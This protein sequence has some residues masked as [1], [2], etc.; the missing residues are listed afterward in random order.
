MKKYIVIIVALI[1]GTFLRLYQIGHI[2][3][4]LTWDEA[5]LGYNAFSILKTGRDEFGKFLPTV[6][7]SFGDF[8]PGLY[9]YLATPFIALVGLT[10]TAVRLPSALF[11]ILSIYGIYLLVKEMFFENKSKELI[12]SFSALVLSLSPSAIH[13]SRGAWETNVF[14]TLLIFIL[15]FLFKFVRLGKY[16]NFSITLFMLSLFTYQ[17]AKILTPILILLL[18]FIYKKDFFKNINKHLTSKINLS[19]FVLFVIATVYFFAN[20]FLGPNSNRLKTLSIFNYHPEVSAET[21]LIDNNNNLSTASFHNKA[22][23]AIHLISGRYFKHLSPKLLFY[24][25]LL[26]VDRGHLPGMGS[27]L[28]FDFIF[29]ILGLVYLSR[30]KNSSGKIFLLGILII[31]PLPGSLTLSDYSTV[32]AHFSLIPIS[33]IIGMGYALIFDNKKIKYTIFTLIFTLIGF[34]FLIDNLFVHANYTYAKEFQFGYREAINFASKYPD[35]KLIM[36]DV[37]GQPYIFYLFYNQY[38]PS[39]Y[40]ST[41]HLELNNLDVGNVSALDNV[42]FHQF[43]TSEFIN[44]PNTVYAGTIGNIPLEYD[45][46]SDSSV[47]DFKNITTPNG[48]V[49]F[50]LVKT[51]NE[52]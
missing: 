7:K 21:K 41:N 37:Y 20:T 3:N 49:I 42:E 9:I 32:R 11:G 25:G 17:A 46:S 36:T 15:F 13:F 50:R 5:A 52:K 6:F 34:V 30:L 19:I 14:S 26:P 39:K 43:S 28:P 47:E 8:K 40:Q 22:Q 12:A 31:S 45:L 2:P 38:S 35:S 29:L 18:I 24:E 33:I 48:E 23:F 44:N 10:E 16:L 1:I 4:A 51:K 27:F